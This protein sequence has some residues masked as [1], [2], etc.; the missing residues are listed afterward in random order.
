MTVELPMKA[1]VEQVQ[2]GHTA[3]LI[4]DVQNDF[5]HPDGLYG[6][7]TAAG[8]GENPFLAAARA[9]GALIVFVRAIYDPAYIAAPQRAI[10]ARYGLFG[11]QCQTDTF[12]ADFFEDVRPKAGAREVV[13]TKHRWSGFVGTVL[14]QVLR[15]N[16]IRTIVVTALPRPCVSS[17]PPATGS[18]TTTTRLG[19]GLLRRSQRRAPCGDD[20]GRQHGLRPRDH[21]PGGDSRLGRTVLR[22]PRMTTREGFAAVDGLRLHYL[23]CGDR[24]RPHLLLVHAGSGPRATLA[25]IPDCT[26]LSSRRRRRSSSFSHGSSRTTSKP[27]VL[28]PKFVEQSSDRAR[29]PSRKENAHAPTRSTDSGVDEKRAKGDR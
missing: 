8:S 23:E 2:P 29:S 28:S 11:V 22:A 16:E 24:S 5:V 14:D 21:R 18:F 3:L 27:S 19:G 6:R 20:P 13:V 15:S 12:G 10:M 25:Q 26:S 9:A 17:R 4:V 7:M 1:L